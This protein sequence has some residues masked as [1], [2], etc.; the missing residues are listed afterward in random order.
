M[1]VPRFGSPGHEYLRKSL[2][3]NFLELALVAKDEDF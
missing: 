2:W 3:T 1:I